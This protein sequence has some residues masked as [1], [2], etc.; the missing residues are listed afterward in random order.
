MSDII[1]RQNVLDV[2]RNLAFDYMFQCGEYYGEDERQLTIINARKAIDVIEAMPSAEPKRTAKVIIHKRYIGTSLNIVGTPNILCEHLCG[3]C[4][5]K[6]IDGD[7]YC[8]HCGTR[9][10]WNE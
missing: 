9:L 10:E 5:K 1:S 3:A 6:V 4:K 2:L 7:N 8:S